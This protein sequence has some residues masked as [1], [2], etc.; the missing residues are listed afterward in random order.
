[1][2]RNHTPLAP[3]VVSSLGVRQPRWIVT[4]YT[5]KLV[6]RQFARMARFQ[7]LQIGLGGAERRLWHRARTHCLSHA[8]ISW[9]TC[10]P[11]LTYQ[12]CWWLELHVAPLLAS[13]RGSSAAPKAQLLRSPC[14]CSAGS[15][16]SPPGYTYRCLDSSSDSSARI[17]RRRTS[18]RRVPI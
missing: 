10:V 7:S 12:W 8:P 13:W 2:V 6:F 5:Y 1:M 11:P 18:S 4:S 15:G 14:G 3:S 16:K 9:C 17:R